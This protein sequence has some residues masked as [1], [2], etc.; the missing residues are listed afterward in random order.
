MLTS[1]D[2]GKPMKSHFKLN[3]HRIVKR[4]AKGFDQTV[5]MRKFAGRT[6]N[7]VGNLIP[8]LIIFITKFQMGNNF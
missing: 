2:S 8:W 3:T 6:Y 7:I 1:V 4:Q 5:H